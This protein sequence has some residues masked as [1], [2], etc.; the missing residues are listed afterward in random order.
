M[1]HATMGLRM[2]PF[3]TASMTR[4]LFDS[5]HLTEEDEH[6]A[7]GVLLVTEEMVDEGRSGV[8][9]T[10]DGDTLVRAVGDERE[11]V[12]QFVGHASGLGDV[13]DRSWAVELGSDDVVHH[14]E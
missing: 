9:V 1:A 5:T 6:L 4:V 8:A 7:V 13:S 2:M 14:S 3:L 12:V 10:T 11:N